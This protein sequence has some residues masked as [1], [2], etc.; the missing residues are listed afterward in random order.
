MKILIALLLLV[1]PAWAS[2]V[3]VLQMTGNVTCAGKR[4][5]LRERIPSG[6]LLEISAGGMVRFGVPGG[7][8]GQVVVG[9]GQFLVPDATDI[10]LERRLEALNLQ[11]SRVQKQLESR[12]TA[13]SEKLARLTGVLA[14]PKVALDLER[15]VV[16]RVRGQVSAGVKQLEVGDLASGRLE[17]QPGSELDL[18]FEGDNRVRTYVG[19]QTVFVPKGADLLEYL[20]ARQR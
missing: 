11:V 12:R 3:E 14:A 15:V 10:Q 7:A 4:I 9:P 8:I 1:L 2:P 19:P 6:T 16:K 20:N 17:V 5:K 18:G 13:A